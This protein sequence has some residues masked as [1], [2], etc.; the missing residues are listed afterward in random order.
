MH[1]FSGYDFERLEAEDSRLNSTETKKR[2]SREPSSRGE[3][4]VYEMLTA[5]GVT[6]RIEKG[7]RGLCSEKGNNLRFD[8]FFPEANTILE[9]H[10][11][12]HYRPSSFQGAIPIDKVDDAFK[13]IQERDIE[14]R[15]FALS[16]GFTYIEVPYLGPAYQLCRDVRLALIK[17]GVL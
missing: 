15:E 4:A 6:F 1:L 7:F 12:Q 2:S 11:A 13:Q 9:I 8:F 17:H 3:R 16:N 14:K 10:G 5:M